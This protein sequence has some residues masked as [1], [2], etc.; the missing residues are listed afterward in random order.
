M[1]RHFGWEHIS[2]INKLLDSG[3]IVYVGSMSS[4]EAPLY[5]PGTDR[6]ISRLWEIIRLVS[7]DTLTH[8]FEE[9]YHIGGAW[10]A[11]YKLENAPRATFD[12][13][14]GELN[15]FLPAYRF[16]IHRGTSRKI[17]KTYA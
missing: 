3:E 13:P 14:F 8:D 4:I 15:L 1:G 11:N 12:T 10:S 17:C 6:E 16:T 2:G 9:L 5:E 7:D